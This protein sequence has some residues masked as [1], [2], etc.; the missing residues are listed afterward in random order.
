[1]IETCL[2][3][4]ALFHTNIGDSTLTTHFP[5][6]CFGV[7]TTLRRAQRSVSRKWPVDI[8]GCIGQWDPYYREMSR[9]RLCE[10]AFR[11]AVDTVWKDERRHHFGPIET[12]PESLLEVDFMELPIAPVD[13]ATGRFFETGNATGSKTPFSNRTHGLIVQT[14]DGVK[15]ATYLPGV[16]PDTPWDEIL[17]SL[18]EKAG[19]DSLEA[20]NIFAY[21]VTQ[22]RKKLIDLLRDGIVCNLSIAHFS[23]FLMAT[24]D[25]GR[26][27]CF[28]YS[29]RCNS[30]ELQWDSDDD[31]RNLATIADL[32]AY[33]KAYPGLFSQGERSQLCAAVARALNDESIH[34]QAL[35]FLGGL[36]LTKNNAFCDRLRAA[37]PGA[38]PEFA[39]P[40]IAIGLWRAGCGATNLSERPKSIFGLNWFIKAQVA[41]GIRPSRQTARFIRTALLAECDA[42][43]RQ[44]NTIE[45]NFLAVAFEALAT[46]RFQETDQRLFEIFFEL[47]RRKAKCGVFYPFRDGVARVDITG[48]VHAGLLAASGASDGNAPKE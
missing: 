35:S 42:L 14:K 15:R 22:L 36:P 18:A 7:F 3:Y 20:T 23:R 46:A 5:T 8:H 37:L 19:I 2:A 28:A 17:T 34:P 39:A 25:P 27:Y 29:V 9:K 43:L 45:T 33:D 40:E 47:E 11:V 24:Q 30:G 38:D 10:T 41:L 48:H 31:V 32:V 4:Y 6:N 21:R 26:R 44:K 12:D 16:F 1:M 13:S